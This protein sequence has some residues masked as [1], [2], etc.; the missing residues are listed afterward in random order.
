MVGLVQVLFISML[1]VFAQHAGFQ[2]AE[3]QHVLEVLYVK[4]SSEHDLKAALA[5]AREEATRPGQFGSGLKQRE[6]SDD[7]G[8]ANIS[9]AI[10]AIKLQESTV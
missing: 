5:F 4:N 1:A 9:N 7:M 10:P 6:V 8:S 2:S 3:F